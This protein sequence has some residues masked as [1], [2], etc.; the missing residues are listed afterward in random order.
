MRSLVVVCMLGLISVLANAGSKKVLIIGID[1]CRPDALI[2]AKTPNIDQLWQDGAYSFSTQTDEISS[3]GICWTGMLTGVWHDKHNVVSNAYANPK[4]EAYPH[5]FRRIKEQYPEMI[6]ASIVNWKPIHN[7]LQE[8]DADIQKRRHFDWWVTYKAQRL[9]KKKKLDVLFVAL[10]EV[11]HAGHVY[12]FSP[13]SSKYIEQIEKADKQVGKI[14]S[15][16]KKRKN[17][18]NEDW[19]VIVT[20]DHGGSG[21]GHGKNIPE[22]TT[23]F[24]IAHGAA[25]KKGQI[26]EDVNVVDVAVTSLK[27]LELDIKDEW[28]LD[29]KVAGLK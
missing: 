3:S 24:Y 7:I 25:V 17:Y 2:A 15:S 26:K 13:D 8:D 14:I 28:Q 11:D 1:G 18:Q 5:F 29:G 12:G 16:L 21:N 27:H 6:T 10:D 9:V 22:H 4:V 20:T 23:I 19:L